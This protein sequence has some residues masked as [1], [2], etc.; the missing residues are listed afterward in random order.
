[1]SPMEKNG[2]APFEGRSV[3]FTRS[4][5]IPNFYPVN[6]QRSRYKQ[7][8]KPVYPDQM[9]VP[10]AVQFGFTVFYPGS[11][12]PWLKMSSKLKRQRQMFYNVFISESK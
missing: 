8:R 1:M 11:A 9:A 10:E 5:P 2:Q 7:D 4:K 6:L 12:G 3:V